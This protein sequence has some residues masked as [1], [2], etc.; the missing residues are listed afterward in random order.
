MKDEL[1]ELDSELNTLRYRETMFFIFDVDNG[2]TKDLHKSIHDNSGWLE[3]GVCRFTQKDIENLNAPRSINE[4]H[5][6]LKDMGI[7]NYFIRDKKG[8]TASPKFNSIRMPYVER[9][10]QIKDIKDQALSTAFQ[11]Y[12]KMISDF[13]KV[14]DFLE[15]EY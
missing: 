4:T 11:E 3:I 1:I 2:K 14:V 6:L 9:L 15:L 8:M 7:K 13:K 12:K 5:E 10:D